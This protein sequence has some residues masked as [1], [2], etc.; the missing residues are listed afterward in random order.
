MKSFLK[1]LLVLLS[2]FFILFLSI[3]LFITALTNTD[4]VVEDNSYLYLPI[5]GTLP[6][7]IAP[8][9]FAELMGNW[10]LDLKKIREN[11]EKA[12]V[13]ERINGVILNLGYI[14]AGYAKINELQHYIEEYKKSNKKIYAFLDFGSTKEYLLATS[15]DSI[16]MPESGNLFITGHG[17]GVTFYKGLFEK[18]GIQADFVHVGEFKDAPESY[19]ES[20]MT[21]SQKLVLNNILDQF[22]ENTINII[23]QK[24]NLASTKVNYLIQNIS[25]FNGNDAL[26]EGLIDAIY[27]KEDVVEL[28][29]YQDEA[30]NLL[31]AYTYSSVPISSLGIRTKSKIAVVHVS[32]TISAGNDVN[33]PIL[34]KLAGSSTI[35]KNIKNA[36]NS[37]STKAIIL[38]INSPGGSAIASD[39]IWKAVKEA[40]KIKPV[41]ASVSDYGASGG[42][43]I[44]M[45]ADTIINN[46][47]SLIGSIGIFAGKF[48]LEN[49]YKKVG[50]GYELIL[51][52]KNAALFSTYSLWSKSERAIIQ[53]LIDDFY[54]NFVTKV[55]ESRNMTY[56]EVDN[57]S[58]G[59]V[60]SGKQGVQN[61]LSDSTG[62]FYDALKFAKK[63]AGIEES[64]SVR[65]SYYPREKDFI[66]EFY[67]LISINNNKL[68]FLKESKSV[69]ISR[70]QNMPLTL[71]PFVIEW[72]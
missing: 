17:A 61:G 30:P 33:D 46:P 38:R 11:L 18:I 55:A 20:K 45:A 13:D 44:A 51:R 71:M 5:S 1:Y 26:Q 43:Y 64:E 23:S 56:K 2:G 48:S 10:T 50:L 58:Q 9:P 68:Q 7:Y 16:F 25:G 12:A 14:R 60:W 28:L 22:Y 72:N 42:Y 21:S 8:N 27:Y 3:F 37:N 24:R 19:T 65:L 6:E 57:I 29:N 69:F 32:G 49:L 34:G 41:V 36:A 31:S 15:C 4:P 66:T 62:T 59:R 35:V 70:F 67:N 63:M 52:G 54:K 40:V 39:E 53:R 47:L